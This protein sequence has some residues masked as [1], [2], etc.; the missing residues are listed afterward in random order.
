MGPKKYINN[1]DTPRL[2]QH[3]SA[4]A[5]VCDPRDPVG[6]VLRAGGLRLR[7]RRAARAARPYRHRAARGDQHDRPLV[8]RQRGVAG[9]GRRRHVRRLPGVVRDDVLRA[10]PGAAAGAAGA[11]GARRG[12]RVPGQERR[13]SLAGDVDMV[14]DARQP[15]DPAADR[16]RPRRPAER[17]ADRLPPRLHRQLLRPAHPLRPVDG[18]HAAR[19]VP[20]ARRHVPEAAHHGRAARAGGR[21]RAA[22]G[23]GGDRA[24]GRLRG[25]D[26]LRRRPYPGPGTR[27]GAGGDRGRVR[28]AAGR[29]RPRRLGLHLLGG[30]D[31]RDG[32]LDLHR[33][34]PAR[35]GVQHQRRLQPDREQ[36]R[37]R[38]L[39]AGGD[40][41]RDGALPAAGAALPGLVVLHLP[42]P[43]RRSRGAGRACAGQLKRPSAAPPR[44]P[45]SGVSPAAR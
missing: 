14:P 35:D 4:H 19:A 9:R 32:R 6:G 37:L 39:R 20:A 41:D 24:G 2:R 15:A 44:S 28:C 21:R 11:D 33:P 22:A 25:L 36:R 38:P 1:P 31:C 17:P 23:L 27:A 40:V 26:A 18:G 8:G 16:R 12:V 10:L 7:R 5:L 45:G 43:R 30:G 3:A 42:R 34:V 13:S 29:Q